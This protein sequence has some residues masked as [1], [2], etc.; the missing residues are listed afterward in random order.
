MSLFCTK[1]GEDPNSTYKIISFNAWPRLI[2]PTLYI[3]FSYCCWQLTVVHSVCKIKQ[4]KLPSVFYCHRRQKPVRWA[5]VQKYL[6][7]QDDS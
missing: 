5:V 1:N 6:W 2:W 7:L 3:T 4:V